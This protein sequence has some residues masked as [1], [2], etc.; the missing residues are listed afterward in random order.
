[1]VT[2]SSPAFRLPL[3]L[4][5]PPVLSVD[6]PGSVPGPHAES[7]GAGT[8]VGVVNGN[9]DPGQ[10]AA[11]AL[12]RALVLDLRN[13]RHIDLPGLCE[14]LGLPKPPEKDESTGRESPELSKRQ[15]MEAVFAMINIEDYLAVLQRFVNRGLSPEQRNQAEDLIW[16]SHEWPVINTRTRREVARA[17]DK[18][19]PFWSDADGLIALVQRRWVDL[20]AAS[21]WP[22]GAGLVHEVSQHLIRNDDW[23]ASDF[24]K[25]VGALECPDRRFALFVHELVSGEVNPD[26][27]RLQLLATTVTGALAASGLRFVETDPIQG[28]PAFMIT[29]STTNPRPTRLLLFAS[30]VAKPDVRLADVL[31]TDVEVLTSSDKLLRYDKPVGRDGLRWQDLLTWWAEQTNTTGSDPK[32]ALWSRLLAAIPPTSPPQRDLF[33]AYHRIYGQCDSFL[34]LLPEVWVHWDPQTVQRRGDDAYSTQR[35]DFLMLLP[36]HRRVVLEVD[37]RQHYSDKGQPSPTAYARTMQG[38]RD[39]RLSGYEVYRFGAREITGPSI[40]DTLRAF[41]DRLLET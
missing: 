37:G 36:N 21:S 16:S 15:R 7:V 34:A 19:V 1:M 14:E 11:G 32:K 18:V 12:V 5:N 31:D 28:Y 9:A 24:F 10:G 39:L 26:V 2:P 30:R 25:R 27:R 3:R 23:T 20:D 29:R 41:F 4:P 38:D 22:L 33:E 8:L 6:A 40:D 17:L 13:H 35:M